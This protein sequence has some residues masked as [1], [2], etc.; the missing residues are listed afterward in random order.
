VVKRQAGW[1]AWIV[2]FLLRLREVDA[3]AW[4]DNNFAEGL[5]IDRPCWYL[6]A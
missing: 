5:T 4:L 3:N 2:H 1:E 6:L